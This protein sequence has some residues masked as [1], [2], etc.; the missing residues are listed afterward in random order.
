MIE[1]FRSISAF[2]K[3]D[4]PSIRTQLGQLPAHIYVQEKN[5]ANSN[6]NSQ[7]I[8]P[9][10]AGM[11]MPGMPGMM[12]MLP[13]MPMMM[14]LM[15]MAAQAQAQSQGQQSKYN[16]LLP[17]TRQGSSSRSILE[18]TNIASKK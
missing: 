5:T 16:A 11:M 9:N 4:W 8:I 13:M 12:P 10:M 1:R 14:P 6:S 15:M 7:G 18:R 17:Q 3:R 2:A